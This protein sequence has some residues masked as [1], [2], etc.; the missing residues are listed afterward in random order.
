MRYLALLASLVAID[1]CGG[2]ELQVGEAASAID[3]SLFQLPSLSEADRAQIVRKYDAVDPDDL[4]PR[5]LLEDALL[6]L[7]VNAAH[8]PKRSDLVVVDLSLFSGEDRFWLVNLSS[9]I[10]EGHKVAHGSGSDPDH[11]G[12]ATSF[13]NT[14]GSLMSSLGFALTAEIY[15]GTHPHSMRLDGLSPDGSPNGME[16]TNM[17]TRYIVVHEASYVDDNNTDKQGRS[18]GCFALDPAIEPDLVD[19]IHDG[20]LL[21]SAQAALND[22]VGRAVC[23]DGMCDGSETD[24]DCPVD[25]QV[26]SPS[27]DGGNID[28]GIDGGGP[29]GPSGQMTGGSTL[30]GGCAVGGTEPGGLGLLVALFWLAGRP[31]RRRHR[32]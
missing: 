15:D 16:N 31:R 11:D 4:V 5:G 29:P 30:V 27:V 22:P 17:R 10:V 8:I 13:S 9:G 12:Y 3:I 21:Y 2:D 26:E 1:G 19:R 14:P 18:E 24:S 28:A 25:C 20:S 6:Y 32:S 7:E 23:G